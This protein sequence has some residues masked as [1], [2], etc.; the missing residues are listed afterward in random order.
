M[1]LSFANL[2]RS[3][4][5]VVVVAVV[6]W[7]VGYPR[8][9]DESVHT[10]DIG[11]TLKAVERIAAYHALIPGGLSE[12]WRPTSA[13]IGH[14]SGHARPTSLHI[15]YVTPDDEYAA[16][17]ESD[18]SRDGFVAATTDRAP[19]A[20]SRVIDGVTWEERAKGSTRSLVRAIGDVTV[21]VTGTASYAELAELAASLR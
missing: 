1:R 18:A 5:V 8:S 19:V 16:L 14:R 17:E 11:P 20:G 12:D 2:A 6:I 10:V 3:L 13:H 15:G 7:L 21:I 9:H 4:A